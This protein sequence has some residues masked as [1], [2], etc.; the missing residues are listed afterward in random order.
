MAQSN[1]LGLVDVDDDWNETFQHVR[2]NLPAQ[3]RSVLLSADYQKPFTS[4]E[5][6]KYMNASLDKYTQHGFQCFIGKIEPILSHIHSFAGIINV[7]VQTHPEIAGLIW[8]S[9]RLL[10]TVIKLPF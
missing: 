2:S 5:I 7:F 3:D 4:V 10:I 1:A 9:L 6:L 8:G